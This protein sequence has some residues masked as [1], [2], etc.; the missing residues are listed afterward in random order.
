MP[1][2]RNNNNRMGSRRGPMGRGRAPRRRVD[3]GPNGNARLT[4]GNGTPG[5]GGS[6]P[7]SQQSAPHTHEV[8]HQHVLAL[9]RH[10]FPGM[11]MSS[12]FAHSGN[13]LGIQSTGSFHSGEAGVHGGHF[14]PGNTMRGQ[15]RSGTGG[16]RQ[17]N[18]R[19][20]GSRNPRRGRRR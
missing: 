8:G 1:Y 15:T 18:R 19:P 13:Q 2:G 17:S 3:R 5:R 20:M 6:M 7:R 14:G 11:N 12:S 10:S 4:R 16:G 9:H